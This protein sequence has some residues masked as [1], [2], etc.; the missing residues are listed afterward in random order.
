MRLPRFLAPSS[1][2]RSLLHT[3]LPTHVP[4]DDDDDPLTDE[5]TIPLTSL[6]PDASFDSA[7]A[8]PSKS[9]SSR[10]TN[11]LSALLSSLPI[12]RILA[13]AVVLVAVYK[14]ATYVYYADYSRI[15]DHLDDYRDRYAA[16]RGYGAKDGAWEMIPV[17]PSVRIRGRRYRSVQED[18]GDKFQ[19]WKAL[20]YALP[21]TGDRRFRVAVPLEERE[22]G[23]EEQETTMGEWDAGP[24]EDRMDGPKEEY[25]GHED[26]LNLY[27]KYWGDVWTRAQRL[28]S[29]RASKYDPAA[30]GFVSG[31]S[32]EA[33][34]HPRELMHLA[35]NELDQ[36]FV[37]VSINYRLGALGF[38]ASP[39][40]PGP[41]P[42]PPHIPTRA[43]TD[44]DLNIG[45]KD[46]ILALKW[47]NEHIAQFGGDPEKVVLVGHSAGAMSVG[48]HMLYTGTRGGN[49]GLFRGAFMLSGAPTSFPVPWPHDAA[50]RTLHPL[51]GPAQCPSPVQ[52]DRG[53]PDNTLLLDCLRA[54]P[55]P[56]LYQAT[57]VLT[58]DSPINA[59]FP[60]YPVLE[61][62]W[63]TGP[64]GVDGKRGGGGWLD[65]R[66]S[67][68]ITRGEYTRIP[69]VMGSVR[70]EG[71]RFVHPEISEGEDEFLAVVRGA[72]RVV[73]PPRLLPMRW[74]DLTRGNGGD[75]A[76]IFDF[77]YGAILDLL[78][79]ILSYYPPPP[80]APES[81]PFAGLSSN[82]PRLA[83]FLG[84]ILFQAPRR[85]FLRETPKDFGEDAWGY[86]Y[87]ERREGAAE[88]MGVQHGAD[89]PAWFNHPA[90][91]D[92]SMMQLSRDMG[93]YLVNFVT[94]LN[95]NGPGL[96]RWPQ[97]TMDRLTLQLARS[98]I[99]VVGDNDRL[100]AMRF[101]NINNPIFA[102]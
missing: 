26:C 76:D 42:T 69:V 91:D 102:R 35:I 89:L 39:P 98:N 53:P 34:Y 13:L 32:S 18:D 11:R 61:G 14:L 68:R 95:P 80:S 52:R 38:T 8:Y 40:P 82:F 88:R 9:S 54:L 94:R 101:L 44:L 41:E 75:V 67:E 49:E 90:A 77:T 46:Q 33:K 99:T 30:G 83:L 62:E 2:S 73:L 47:V 81:G 48:L 16:W 29:A 45:L 64:T 85:H 92:E 65:V 17:L 70:D 15:S 84:D 10:S 72:S 66:P 57:R 55:L 93:A 6:D 37:F 50:A 86:V 96:P 51:P 97:Y 1:S 22:D 74:T 58:D 28:L 5:A 36:P 12:R 31:S 60:Y 43:P 23:G 4:H 3:R 63:G 87:E 78:E 7:A 56:S 20:P 100:E 25:D 21:P 27:T 79:P 19:S 24:R 59:W 71:N